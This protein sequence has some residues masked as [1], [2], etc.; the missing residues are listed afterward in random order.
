VN[1]VEILYV[2]AMPEPA[3]PGHQDW[4]SVQEGGA[5]LDVDP[6]TLA[7]D[8]VRLAVS[9]RDAASEAQ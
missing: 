1:A 6:G 5:R 2:L 3:R 4:P 7:R 8:H 9:Y